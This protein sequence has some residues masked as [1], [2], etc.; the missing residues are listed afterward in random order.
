MRLDVLLPELTNSENDNLS[1]VVSD[2]I[3]KFWNLWLTPNEIKKTTSLYSI[4]SSTLTPQ[5][6]KLGK[7]EITI[8]VT[9]MTTGMEVTMK[10]VLNVLS[11]AE[12]AY[13]ALL[14]AEGSVHASIH[15]G[16]SVLSDGSKV[17]NSVV[18]ENIFN[19]QISNKLDVKSMAID[20]ELFKPN[21][22]N[23]A[24]Q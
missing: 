21:Q 3:N 16:G 20:C 14:L 11:E 19:V 17:D 4:H 23:L 1:I 24:S 10:Y 15:S 9:D 5:T 6:V 13:E 18:T 8:L 22:D 12:F 7:S 2:S